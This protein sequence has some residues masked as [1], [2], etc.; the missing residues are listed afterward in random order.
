MNKIAD[1]V[2]L[3]TGYANF[4]ELKS[5]FDEAQENSA[6]MAMYRPTKAHRRA[7]KRICQGL[8]MPN[9]K[10]FYLLSGSYGTGKSHLSLMLANVL[11]RSSGD[12][13]IRGF[14]ENYEKL[15]PDTAQTLRNVRKNGQYLVAICDYYSGMRFEDVV[16]KAIFEACERMGLET[17]VQTAFDEAERL[18]T[19]WEEDSRDGSAFRNFYA[20]FADALEQIA[21]GMP[22]D[23]L[24]ACL[25]DY[26][27]EAL[28]QFR[29]AY[30]L[31]QGGA[32]FQ[33]QSGNLVPIVQKLVR[34]RE[35]RDRF[36]GLAIFFDEFGFTL[37]KAAYSKDVLQGFM[38]T[39]CKNEPNVLFVGC[40]HKDFRH[41]ADRLSQA[42]AEVMS[43]RLTQVELLNEGIEEIIGAIVEVDK[44]CDAWENQVA[45]KLGVLDTLLPQCQTLN[46]FP[47]IEDIDRIR[48][49]VLEDIYG[50]HP[51]ALACLLRLSS[52]LGSDVR[53]TFTFFS[54]EV[55]GDTGSY[56]EF[57]ENA[58][59]TVDGGPLRLYRTP[60]LYDF[61]KSELSPKNPQLRDRQRQLVNG[62]ISSVEAVRKISQ[63]ELLQEEE[64]FRIELIR[65]ILLYELCQ[66]PTTLENIQ[67]GMYCLSKPENRR[68]ESELKKLEQA[69][70]LYL[71]RQSNTYELATSDS[72]DPN[73]LIERYLQKTS[74][75]TS[76]DALVA[77]AAAQEDVTYLEAKQYN[78]A[79]NEDKRLFRRFVRARDLGPEL[80]K[81]LGEEL[82]QAA[83]S[84]AKS[85]EGIAVYV[86]CEDEPEVHQ[87]RDNID[88]IDRA[89][90][91]AGVPNEPFA[92]GDLLRRVKACRHYLSPEEANKLTAQTVARLRDM[93]D[94]PGDGFY[95]QLKRQFQG[96]LSG[97]S[98]CWH[99][100]GGRVLVDRPQQSH[101]PA[102]TMMEGL[103]TRRCRIKNPDLNLIHDDK[104]LKGRNSALKQAADIFLDTENPVHIDNGH[105]ANHGQKR[106]LQSVFLSGAGAL[107]Q[108]VQ[109]GTVTF[110]QCETDTS[111]LSDDFPVLKEL[112]SRLSAGG[113]LSIRRFVE[114]SKS[115]PFGAGGT[116]LV[117]AL[118]YAIRAF[119]EGLRIYA[120]STGTKPVSRSEIDCNRLVT[121]VSSPTDDTHFDVSEIS[122]AHRLLVRRIADAAGAA[123]L[124]HGTNRKV[125]DAHTA[126]R[127]WWL[128][129]PNAATNPDIHDTSRSGR[130]AQLV[131]TL[132]SIDTTDPFELMFSLIPQVYS[133]HPLSSKTAN[134]EIEQICSD[135]AADVECLNTGYQQVANAVSDAVCR[136]FGGEGDV[137]ECEKQ[138]QTWFKNLNPTQRQSHRFEDDAR[139][140]VAV[141]ND[142]ATSFEEKLLTA[143][144]TRF[145]LG[146]VREW[147]TLKVDDYAG[148]WRQAK[149]AIDE[150]KPV[151]PLPDIQTFGAIH[152]EA[153]SVWNVDTDGK[154]EIKVPGGATGLIYTTNNEDPKQASNA[155]K[156]EGTLLIGQ[157]T[158][159]TATATFCMRTIDEQG[160][161]SD[162]VRLQ[163]VNKA[164]EYDV[165]TQDDLYLPKGAFKMPETA[166]DFL[167]VL[168]SMVNLGRKR[169]LLTDQQA[170]TLLT[171]IDNLKK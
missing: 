39:I 112:C 28:D 4:V 34:S 157:E 143:I 1:I 69:G 150:A 110:F 87:A 94:N 27:S 16:L 52:E 41:Y 122:Q 77:E 98:A 89:D 99:G 43:A 35:F 126:L 62:Y 154:L 168:R 75:D 86:I 146:A 117:L 140:L 73:D 108:T 113:T 97:E 78:L 123:P 68:V 61:F 85:A 163:V 129:L 96:V 38:E 171:C 100:R 101:R 37:E 9:D 60:L 22:I 120:D 30:R 107:K 82:E 115:S 15:E 5:A 29:S 169:A 63:G 7:F 32:E 149:R 160:N 45:P 72:V 3:K 127:D 133:D 70:A 144:P 111:A 114:E 50:V 124:A 49:R 57:I 155:Q 33:A 14:Y 8:H 66:V 91:I 159:G 26:N 95:S 116:M 170:E 51:M 128:S 166:G 21:P 31:A 165:E 102:D 162:L 64:D 93:L 138:V 59:I 67:F 103:Y 44:N 104:W 135:F 13:D 46:L 40:I 119:E 17:G 2:Q 136:L 25:R 142:G 80:W 20:D 6:R 167:A 42:D 24:R 74:I 132:Q 118:A 71:R 105:P 58:D 92:Y 76:V 151:L 152:E 134:K 141:L 137:V 79:F 109:E 56:A 11:S 125:T 18:L 147:T 23:Q 54:G 10:K 130:L 161:M 65:T 83:K 90:V 88:S 148:K 19:K 145:G 12:P 81:A 131:Q 156:V 158:I 164:R 48:E 36:V 139:E 55:G 84:D 106:Y 153:D 53:S 47:W 121:M